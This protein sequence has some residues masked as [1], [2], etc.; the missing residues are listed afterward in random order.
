MRK[1]PPDM[2]MMGEGMGTMICST[3][4][5]MNIDKAPWVLTI[6]R[7]ALRIWVM[8]KSIARKEKQKTRKMLE[9][10]YGNR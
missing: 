1:A 9:L 5:P 2:V 6:A 8:R 3:T 7:I 10:D 4:P